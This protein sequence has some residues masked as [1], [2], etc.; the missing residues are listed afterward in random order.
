MMVKRKLDSAVDE[1]SVNQDICTCK[2]DV[3]VQIWRPAPSRTRSYG[4][5]YVGQNLGKA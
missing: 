4:T 1:S 3:T 5:Q 2:S